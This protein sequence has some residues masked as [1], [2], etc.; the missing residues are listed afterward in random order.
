MN[1]ILLIGGAVA[2][3]YVG[4]FLGLGGGIV[5]VPF[6]TLI[7]GMPMH[8]AVALSLAAIMANSIVSSNNYLK[9]NMVDFRLVIPLCIF[10]SL[11]AVA[12]SSTIHLIPGDYLKIVFAIALT[13]TAVSIIRKKDN[14]RQNAGGRKTEPKL[15]TISIIA[16]LSGVFSSLLGVGGGIIIIPAVFLIL[17]YSIHTA[18]GSSAF[19]IGITATAGSIVYLLNG[20]LVLDKIGP[21]ILGLTV[22]GWFGSWCGARAGSFMVRLAFAIILLYLAVRMFIQGVG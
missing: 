11:G 9:K 3:G 4:G 8:Q 6:L 21:V 13:Y 20:T 7:F 16:F 1:P 19:T 2:A 22:G 10:A 12:G 17:N 14:N 5:L 18:R 15:I